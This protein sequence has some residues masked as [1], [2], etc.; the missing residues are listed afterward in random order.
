MNKNDLI[1]HRSY[2]PTDKA[3]IFATWLRGYKGGAQ[4]FRK[5]PG[6]I[7]QLHYQRV[8]Q[9]LLEDRTIKIA[10][11]LEDP[12]VIIGYCIYKGDRVDWVYVKENWRKIG[13]AKDLL[14]ATF[15]S[16]SHMT[17]VAFEILKK[18]PKIIY[19][20]FL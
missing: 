18:Y 3:F 4:W 17:N 10:C 14:P 19:N 15:T 20:P 11:L 1:T 7:F 12:D 5:I 6:Q 16:V 13:I 8:I 9:K 2:H